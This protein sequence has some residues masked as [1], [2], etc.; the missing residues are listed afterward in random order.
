MPKIALVHEFLTQL[1]GAERVL[2]ALHEIFPAASVYTLVHDK[3]KTQGVFANWD[4]RPSFLQQLPGGVKSYKWYLFLMPKAI[5]SFDFSGFD[6]VLS[7]SSAFA[8]GVITKKPTI[9]ICYTHTP[10]RYLWQDLNSYVAQAR[11]P[12]IL[13][14][15]I[16]S[17]LKH[18]LRSWDYDAAQK[19]DFLIAN[20]QTVG[21]RVKQYYDRESEVIYPPVDT[22]FF[23]PVANKQNY[24]FTASRLE[25]YKKIELAIEAFNQLKLPLKVAGDGTEL[26]KL[27]I[28][29]QKSNIEFLGRVTD[30]ELRNLYAGAKAFI[31]PAY[32][33][34]GIMVLE[35]LACGTPVIG[36]QRG[37][38]AEFI[39]DGENGVLFAEQTVDSLLTA[40][41]KISTMKFDPFKL[42]ESA[43]PFDKERFKEKILAFIKAHK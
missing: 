40:V 5:E 33:D 15:I 16:K 26:K 6:L 9:H 12:A 2:Q 36:F 4:V 17:Y 14:P 18:Y 3:A 34:A 42:R 11:I 25:P 38:T 20:S 30:E 8:K 35:A 37:G 31:F 10:T 1:G 41:K 32:E 29:Y 43:L 24:F 21:E 13:K 39:R 22:E 27:K 28:K 7:D 23:K 19:P